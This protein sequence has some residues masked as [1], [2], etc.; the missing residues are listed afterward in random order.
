MNRGQQLGALA[1][2]N[3]QKYLPFVPEVLRWQNTQLDSELRIR[4]SE[5][6][7]Q[8]WSPVGQLMDLNDGGQIQRVQ[9]ETFARGNFGIVTDGYGEGI[10]II[11][12]KNGSGLQTFEHDI[13]VPSAG[14]YQLD[15]RYAA[16]TARPGKLFL[17]GVLVKSAAIG[18][19]T[20]GWNP[21]NQKWHVSGRYNF[22]AGNN[23]LRFEVQNV[24]SHIDQIAIS[25]VLEDFGHVRE[26][27]DFDRGD[28]SQ[29]NQGYGEGIGIAATS[30]NNEL[31]FIEYDLNDIAPG[32]YVLQF[33][34]ASDAVRPMKLII[35][36]KLIDDQA[37]QEVT[38]GWNPENQKWITVGELKLSQPH[39]VLR[40][41]A[42]KVSVHLDKLRLIPHVAES[43]LPSLMEIATKHQ[44]DHRVL[45]RW[46]TVAKQ[47]SATTPA[48]D[49]WL[50]KGEAAP[51][52]LT[53]PEATAVTKLLFA[54]ALRR[55]L[56]ESD[57]KRIVEIDAEISRNRQQLEKLKS[58]VAMAAAEGDVSD[59]QIHIRGSHLQKG[60]V[61]ARRAPRILTR[62]EVAGLE[63]Q[64]SGRLELAQAMEQNHL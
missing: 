61:V 31:T 62:S 51:Q 40:L 19:V 28:F 30:K 53:N 34:Y 59:M 10:G 12:D 49:A 29:I 16:A 63:T 24:M 4:L 38:G 8:P 57:D 47:I 1:Q 44:L 45:N 9:A 52:L 54:P 17:N 41:E 21:E 7:D 5:S 55:E 46:V 56:S 15:I 27:E 25:P 33:R 35:D 43:M 11:S 64:Q 42:S 39:H 37:F 2:L 18:E 60:D 14:K 23:V 26:A 20:G 48:V 50:R 58:L 13:F 36:D 22:K 32:K 3:A 6:A